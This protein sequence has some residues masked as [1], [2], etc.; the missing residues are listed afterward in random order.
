MVHNDMLP[1]IFTREIEK[2]ELRLSMI[3]DDGDLPVVN[4]VPNIR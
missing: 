3:S 4:C 2:P 1:Y